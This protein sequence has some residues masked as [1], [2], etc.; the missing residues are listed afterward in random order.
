MMWIYLLAGLVLV[1]LAWQDG[2]SH[3]LPDPLI[4]LLVFCGVI[5]RIWDGQLLGGVIGI[6]I[7]G[8]PILVL[9]VILRHGTGIGGADV[10]LCAA[11]GLL[12]GPLDGSMVMLIALMGLSLWGL[13]TDR[14]DKPIPYG[15]FVLPAYMAVI[16]LRW[17]GLI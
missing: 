1:A 16:F 17:K 8:L 15:P 3:T 13:L 11:M 14:T 6:L 10:K 4:L 12:L 7:C 5:R 9:S 2:I